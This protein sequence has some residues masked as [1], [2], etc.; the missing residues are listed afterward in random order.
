MP[1]RKNSQGFELFNDGLLT[2]CDA[3]ERILTSTKLEKIRYGNRTIGV[4]RYFQAKTAGNKV[5]KLLSIPMEAADIDLIEVEDV[6][7]LNHESAQYQ[8]VQIQ[9]KFDAKPPAIYLSLEKLVH[10]YKDK[11][12]S[13]G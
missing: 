12:D 8:I 4:S 13:D 11:R 9:E 2:V 7:I 3:D 1:Q 6:V 5:S 10:P